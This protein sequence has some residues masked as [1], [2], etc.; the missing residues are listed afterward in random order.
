MFASIVNRIKTYSDEVLKIDQDSF[1]EDDF[2]KYQAIYTRSMVEGSNALIRPFA[3]L[4]LQC[5]KNPA[6]ALIAR[7]QFERLLKNR[8]ATIENRPENALLL[9][10]LEAQDE[11]KY[12][13]EWI[14]LNSLEDRKY[15]MDLG[16]VE[17]RIEELESEL[18][19]MKDVYPSE[20]SGAYERKGVNFFSLAREVGMERMHRSIYS[21]LSKWAHGSFI[22]GGEIE[23]VNSINWLCLTTPIELA[24]A[25]AEL[26]NEPTP[27]MNI[28]EDIV[29]F[30]NRS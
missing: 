8:F 2:K 24:T 14:R 5:A 18:A 15:T 3:V 13:K 20:D 30:C 29:A 22:A 28:L 26:L 7:T 12:H 27:P 11:L 6:L 4:S 9:M 25:L 21:D 17:I 23:T 16:N 19:I 10:I 1:P